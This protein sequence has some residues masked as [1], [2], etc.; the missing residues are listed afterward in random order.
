[1]QVHK[2]HK[3]FCFSLDKYTNKYYYEPTDKEKLLGGVFVWM[4][5]V[6]L[7]SKRRRPVRLTPGVGFQ[8]PQQRLPVGWCSGCGAQLHDPQQTMCRR[9]KGGTEDEEESLYDLQPGEMPG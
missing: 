6:Y 1:M 4:N 5:F 3:T 8:D 7:K 2:P 9:C